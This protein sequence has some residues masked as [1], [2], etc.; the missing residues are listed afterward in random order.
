VQGP[1]LFNI[2]LERGIGNVELTTM[3]PF[4]MKKAVLSIHCMQMMLQ[5]LGNWWE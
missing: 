5:Y 3:E 1:Q 4:L 2:V